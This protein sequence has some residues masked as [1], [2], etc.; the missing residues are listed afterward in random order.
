MPTEQTIQLPPDATANKN[1]MRALSLTTEGST[2]GTANTTLQEA[3]TLADADGNLIPA[4][5]GLS[6]ADAEMRGLLT[7][8]RDSL[9][10]IV[11]I[12]G[13]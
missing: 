9:Q 4:W 6:V 10:L 5:N 12:L 2:T 11:G 7:D 8:I 1:L 3:V 13:K